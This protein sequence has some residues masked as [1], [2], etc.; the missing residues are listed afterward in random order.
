MICRLGSVVKNL[1]AAIQETWV[2]SLGWEDPRRRAWQPTPVFLPGKSHGQRNLAGY[3]PWGVAKSRTR[4]KDKDFF[5]RL[6]RAFLGIV[7]LAVTQLCETRSVE[8]KKGD[9]VF[10][11]TPKPL[12]L[13]H[14]PTSSPSLGPE[15]FPAF[16]PPGSCTQTF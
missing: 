11:R 3:S 7:W 1:P 12:V 14:A 5:Y 15:P 2:P 4:L 16:C 13:E 6:F 10:P 8:A 9:S